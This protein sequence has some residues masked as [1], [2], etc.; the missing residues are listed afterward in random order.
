MKRSGTQ[1]CVFA[2]LRFTFCV[3]GIAPVGEKTKRAMMQHSLHGNAMILHACI[4]LLYFCDMIHYFERFV[5]G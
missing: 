5:G 1:I 4:V 3:F 2:Y